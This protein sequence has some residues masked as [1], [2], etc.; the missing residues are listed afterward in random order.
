[1]Y[2]NIQ[3]NY[4][5]LQNCVCDNRQVDLGGL[6]SL[7]AVLVGPKPGIKCLVVGSTPHH[8]GNVCPAK[9][10]KKRFS[11]GFVTIDGQNCKRHIYTYTNVC[12]YTTKIL[13]LYILFT[14]FEHYVVSLLSASSLLTLHNCFYLNYLWPN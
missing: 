8:V 11:E 3:K 5:F 6:N 1:M 2:K 14:C 4:T 12:L 13:I 9:R 7:L 10:L